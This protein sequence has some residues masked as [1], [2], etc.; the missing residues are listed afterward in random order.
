MADNIEIKAAVADLAC[1]RALADRLDV[2]ERFRLTQTDTFFNAPSG[3]L[4]LREFADGSAE[5]IGYDRPDRAGPKHSRYQ[6][7][8]VAE[9]AAL[10]EALDMTLGVRG[11]VRKKRDV[12]LVGQTRIHL[13][14]VEG[15]GTF[16]ELEVVIEDGQD[17]ADGERIARGLLEALRIGDDDL[18]SCAY[19]D[20][21]DGR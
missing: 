17:H 9:P 18:I 21:L 14:E 12:L 19:I 4:K 10:I 11:V 5:L 8:A 2:R 20:L 13:D 3:R 1:V 6:K 16:V 15:L 7:V